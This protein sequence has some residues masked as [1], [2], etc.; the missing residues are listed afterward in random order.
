MAFDWFASRKSDSAVTH[1]SSRNKATFKPNL[2]TL[3]DRIV[4]AF[5]YG[6][7]PLL[8]NVAVQG[9]YL[10]SDW[11]NTAAGNP[12]PASTSYFD[13]Y[14]KYMVSSPFMTMLHVDGY[15]VNKGTFAPGVIDPVSLTQR[16]R[17]VFL[18][19]SQI[20]SDV[21]AEITANK[22][23]QPGANSL[24]VVFVEDNVPVETTYGANSI[25]NFS[26]YHSMFVG[27]NS[28]GQLEN[29]YYAVIP[30]PG[31]SVGNVYGVQTNTVTQAQ[32]MTIVGSHE[33]AEAATD[34]I[35]GLGWY[36]F[37]NIGEVGDL[38]KGQYYFLHGYAMQRIAA[39][40]DQAMTPAGAAPLTPETFILEKNGNLYEHT[41]SGNTLVASGVA[42]ITNQTFSLFGRAIVDYVDTSGNGWSYDDVNGNLEI[43]NTA[44]VK[45][46]VD[47]QG[48]DF[49]L[50]TNGTLIEQ[51]LVPGN[52][53]SILGPW[54]DKTVAT[55]VVSISGGTDVY[56]L[57]DVA[58]VTSTGAAYEYSLL[59]S[60][61]IAASGVAS[62]SAGQGGQVGVVLTTGQ[63]NLW[64][65]A[66]NKTT[67]LAASG[68]KQLT[69][70]TAANGATLVERLDT[71]GNLWEYDNGTA[72]APTQINS[73][74]ASISDARLGVVDAIMSNGTAQEHKGTTWTTIDSNTVTG[75][76]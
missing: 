4:P 15:N 1:R 8:T 70:G 30:T 42:S 59:G 33:V 28:S 60:H 69:L 6:G 34:P 35:P 49:I 76:G 20:Q 3:E 23:Q 32:E 55:N 18:T 73:N 37:T 31:G 45:Q 68:V 48:T 26:G 54:S 11:S 41:S 43:Q 2:E 10:G 57:A 72:N 50:L 47:S 62:V 52:F 14:L 13:G 39:K 5:T 71:N 29:I 63:A 58:Y 25:H 75:A 44:N 16:T 21:Q 64:T 24:Y 65:Q 74:V 61:Q 53:P 67:M 7:G 46:V 12:N 9:I 40:N 38:T 19:D 22:V 17:S 36:D 27:T 66:G 56:G 51:T